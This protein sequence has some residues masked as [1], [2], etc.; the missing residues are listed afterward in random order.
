MKRM[1]YKRMEDNKWEEQTKYIERQ[2]GILATYAALTTHTLSAKAG[3]PSPYP[4]SYAWRWAARS[5]N[6]PAGGEIEAAMMAAFLE[7]T[8]QAL[9][10]GYGRQA[11]K[12]VRVALGGEWVAAVVRGPATGRL[13]VMADEFARTGRIGED[14][15]GG[16]VP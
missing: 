16:F 7:V 5:L 4:L 1:G 11:Q 14:G 2:A 12:L 10:K 9:L 15:F 13:E 8:N 6:H 3:T